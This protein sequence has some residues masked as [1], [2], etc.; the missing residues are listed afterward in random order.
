MK[1]K[2][3]LLWQSPWFALFKQCLFA[4]CRLK[5]NTET[6]K[7]QPMT[8][9]PKATTPTNATSGVGDDPKE[10]R[11]VR[12]NPANDVSMKTMTPKMAPKKIPNSIIIGLDKDSSTIT[13]FTSSTA[14][15]TTTPKSKRV[16]T[17]TTTT[18]SVTANV[19]QT[20]LG[21]NATSLGNSC[22]VVVE[23]NKNLAQKRI[24]T[25]SAKTT[26]GTFYFKTVQ[27][28]AFWCRPM[29]K[30]FGFVIFGKNK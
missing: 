30:P 14:T 1:H 26:S 17:T 7:G 12:Q 2:S 9:K 11:S 3:S 8:P 27:H 19:S 23:T 6:N 15:A 16:T 24:K 28:H 5:N 20:T 18:A 22:N 4:D 13:D 29:K 25:R 10:R 21:V